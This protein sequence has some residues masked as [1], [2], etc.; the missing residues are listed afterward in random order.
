LTGVNDADYTP[1]FPLTAKLNKLTIKL[2]RPQ[3][4]PDDIKKLEGAMSAAA[5]GPV[6]G[7]LSLVQRLEE[8]FDKR[9]DCRKQADAQKLDPIERLQFVRKCLQ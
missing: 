6:S 8:R 3:L 7:D 1:P 2:D 4:T 9:E 5:D